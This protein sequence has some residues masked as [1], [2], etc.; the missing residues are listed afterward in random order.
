MPSKKW[1]MACDKL[2]R[3]YNIIIISDCSGGKGKEE[4]YYLKG[5][6]Y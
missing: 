2:K 1:Y 5:E 6:K 3:E 4:H